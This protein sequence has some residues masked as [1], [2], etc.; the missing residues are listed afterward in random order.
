MDKETSEIIWI[1]KAIAIFCVVCAHSALINEDSGNTNQFVSS[2]L[3]YIGTMGVPLFFILSGY[4][5][6]FNKKSF[7]LFWRNKVK[8]LFLPWLF[9]ETLLW[10]YIV[11]RKGGIGFRSWCL[12]LIGYGH[13]TYYLTILTILLDFLDYKKEIYVLWNYRT[14]I[15]Q[16]YINRL[17]YWN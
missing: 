16:Y 3:N 6:T 2:I 1:A 9:C 12:F 13:T 10:L 5:F 4:L 11:I 14:F 17:G 8:T 15:N 7:G